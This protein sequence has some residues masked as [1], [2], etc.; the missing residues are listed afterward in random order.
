MVKDYAMFTDRGNVAVG[1]IVDIARQV[2]LTWDQVETALRNLAMK[3]E[4]SESMDT[5]VRECV[6]IALGFDE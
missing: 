2:G 4:Y 3:D 1:T 6:Y 5:A